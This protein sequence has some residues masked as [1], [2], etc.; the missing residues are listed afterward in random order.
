MVWWVKPSAHYI[1]NNCSHKKPAE[2]NSYLLWPAR[3]L[4]A[5]ARRLRG[6]SEPTVLWVTWVV[7]IP[8]P[9]A[10][11]GHLLP[12]SL[13]L[14]LKLSLSLSQA[15]CS[16]LPC[17]NLCDSLRDLALES[18]RKLEKILLL[19]SCALGEAL[20]A[21]CVCYSWSLAPRRLAVAR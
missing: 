1:S 20:T 2:L 12:H 7:F 3:S 15:W 18:V 16:Q 4:H 13:R 17:S 9:F 6:L 14:E 11:N 21:W 5:Q 19:C 10:P 8:Y